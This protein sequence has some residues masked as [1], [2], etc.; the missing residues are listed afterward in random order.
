MSVL[1]T[2]FSALSAAP[3]GNV[4]P[5]TGQGAEWGKGAPIGLF[6]ILV[7]SIA[8]FFLLR[9]MTRNMRKVPASFETADESDQS[10]PDVSKDGDS[11]SDQVAA[12]MDKPAQHSP[13][14]QAEQEPADRG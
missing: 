13:N 6:V 7:M 5:T 3:P 1:M 10:K 9:S 4:D 14:E 11:P 8:V 12:R 2:V